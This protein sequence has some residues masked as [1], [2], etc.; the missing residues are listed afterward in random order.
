M[1]D[2]PLILEILALPNFSDAVG[3]A[4]EMTAERVNDGSG[5]LERL[6]KQLDDLH[7]KLDSLS[8]VQTDVNTR[9]RELEKKTES[10]IEAIRDV[11]RVAKGELVQQE[12]GQGSNCL[13]KGPDVK[14][15]PPQINTENSKTD[16]LKNRHN[17]ND[18]DDAKYELKRLKQTIEDSGSSS[19]LR[20]LRLVNRSLD[21]ESVDEIYKNIRLMLKIAKRGDR[22]HDR[23]LISSLEVASW[24]VGQMKDTK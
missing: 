4:I 21:T 9:L 6:G 7:Q 23:K 14:E 22:F 2:R 1:D 11:G 13:S 16:V 15:K 17:E 18:L 19:K 10:A 12:E 5:G 3:E 24:E 20:Y 8:E